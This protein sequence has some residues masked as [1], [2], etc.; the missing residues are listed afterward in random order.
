MRLNFRLKATI[1]RNSSARPVLVVVGAT[2]AQL[3]RA[4]DCGSRG[5]RSIGEAVPF[6]LK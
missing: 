6:F 1:F 5:P 2:L 3:V 4:L